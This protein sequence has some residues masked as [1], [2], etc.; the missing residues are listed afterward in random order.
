MIIEFINRR[1]SKD[2]NWLNGN[3]FWFALILKERFPF[4]KI[5]YLPIDGHFV[6]G[7]GNKYYDWSGE[8]D[9]EEKP[10]EL[11]EIKETDILWYEKLMR[12]CF[13]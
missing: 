5:Y 10:Y 4:L 2:C 8:I 12:D 11:N 7:D 3:C 13:A 1:F 6:V 9:L